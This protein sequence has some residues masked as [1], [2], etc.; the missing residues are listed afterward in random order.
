MHI[1]HELLE[2]IK[3]IECPTDDVAERIIS[4]LESYSPE[5]EYQVTQ[6]EDDDFIHDG[7]KVYK[8][9]SETPESPSIEAVVKEGQDHYVARV[10]D[11][12]EM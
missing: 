8:I 9:Y 11:A 10:I 7:I 6:R 1:S 5:G 3:G 12:Y 4:V 2:K